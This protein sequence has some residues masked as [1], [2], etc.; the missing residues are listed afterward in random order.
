MNAILVST[1]AFVSALLGGIVCDKL[2]KNG[3]EKIKANL[4]IASSVLTIPF[5]VCCT[6]IQ[7]SIWFSISMLG[8]VY[9]FGEAWISPAVT[10]LINTISPENK[11][12][13]YSVYL[14][15]CTISGTLAVSMLGFLEQALDTSKDNKRVNGILIALF[16]G[17]SFALSIPFFVLA[18]RS[19]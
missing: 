13:G 12:S 11:A 14:F 6:C 8:F 4:C 15:V 5:I 7:S 3:Y 1:C 2:E 9:L 19:Y 18:G 17:V 10:M 16:V